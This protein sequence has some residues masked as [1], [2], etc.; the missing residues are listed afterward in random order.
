MLVLLCAYAT[1]VD[2]GVFDHSAPESELEETLVDKEN[3]N[4]CTEPRERSVLVRSFSIAQTYHALFDYDEKRKH[5]LDGLRALSLSWIIL[6]HTINFML[7]IGMSN[8]L[9]FY[10]LNGSN[11]AFAC[12]PWFSI[13]VVSANFAVDTFFFLSSFLLTMVMLRR[14]ER[15][16]SLPILLAVASRYIRL[17]P[18][19]AFVILLF[20][21][22]VPYTGSGPFWYLVTDLVRNCGDRWWTNVLFVNNFY[23]HD[24]K[25]QCVPWTWYLANDFQF[26]LVAL[27]I[28][29]VMRKW[30][31]KVQVSCL[32]TLLVGSIAA[33]ATIAWKHGAKFIDLAN[34]NLMQN[35]IYDKPYTRIGPYLIGMITAYVYVKT[36]TRIGRKAQIAAW[37]AI[38]ACLIVPPAV[39]YTD[40]CP[41]FRFRASGAMPPTLRIS[42]YHVPFG[43]LASRF[44]FI[45]ACERMVASS[46]RLYLGN[47]GCN[48]KVDVF[49]VLGPPHIDSDRPVQSP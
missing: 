4:G 46:T 27:M 15:G 37:F 19:L 24:Y 32:T 12:S 40:L 28:I 31:L 18:T 3:G 34:P 38:A 10:P 30:S 8:P 2:A 5:V 22:I 49:S 7:D 44:S 11:G 33:T 13:F 9:D 6:G 25:A 14:I 39:T 1:A 26:F 47:L 41:N 36:N 23:P 43:H 29:L 48:G 17:V 42:L 21:L 45:C 16:S 35:L 20:T